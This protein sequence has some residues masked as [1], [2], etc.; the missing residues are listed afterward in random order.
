MPRP[1]DI[2]FDVVDRIA[3]YFA[4]E[5]NVITIDGARIQFEHGW[6]LVRPSNTQAIL[7][8]RFEAD[9]DEE[10]KEIRNVVETKVADFIK[11]S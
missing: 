1:D 11:A 6:G 8:L 3:D 9:T 5:H 4:R 10:L 2:K 7:V